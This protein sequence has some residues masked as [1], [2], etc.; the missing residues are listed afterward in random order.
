MPYKL[1]SINYQ[2]KLGDYKMQ[3]F[4]LKIAKSIKLLQYMYA[5]NSSP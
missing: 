2:G 5:L 3:K 4:K 1:R